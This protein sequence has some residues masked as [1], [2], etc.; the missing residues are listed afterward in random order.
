DLIQADLSGAH[1]SGA[2]LG[3]ANLEETVLGFTSF[4]S[5]NLADVKGLETAKHIAPSTIG[6]D[7]L[8]LS[9]GR[10]PE[11]FLRGCGLPDDLIT[12]LPSLVNAHEALVSYACFISYAHEDAGFVQHLHSRMRQE[13]LRVWLDEEGKKLPDRIEKPFGTYDKLFVV[14]SEASME[15]E[16][17][18]SEVRRVL[19]AET[20]PGPRK[21]FPIRLVD[22]DMINNWEAPGVIGGEPL[23]LAVQK[24]FVADFTD[25]KHEEAFESAFALLL[26]SLRAAAEE[27]T[28]G[29]IQAQTV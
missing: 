15:S 11:V 22:V 21:L 3:R 6:V 4:A 7:T 19:T 18:Q 16:W 27:V 25:W 23:S 8:Y 29:P 12:Q 2:H 9:Q 17:V 13:H 28:N 1:L 26:R 24:Y 5:L 20:R 10:I 14:L